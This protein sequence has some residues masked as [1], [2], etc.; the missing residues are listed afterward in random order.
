MSSDG[1]KINVTE[2]IIEKSVHVEAIKTMFYF[3]FNDKFEDKLEEHIQWEMVYVDRGEC[4]VFSD[5]DRY[6]LSQGEMYFHKPF[7]KH[8]IEVKKNTFPNIFIISFKSSS[9]ALHTLAKRKIS[10]PM[11]IKQHITAIIHEASLTYSSLHITGSTLRAES[12]LW[13][14]EQSILLRLELMLI[15][16][17]RQKEQGTTKKKLFVSKKTIDDEFCIRIIEYMEEKIYDKFSLDE[18]SARLSYSKSYISKHFMSVCGISIIEY[19]NMMKIEEAKM[20]IRGTNKSF[21]EISEMLMLTN[22][23]YFSTLFKKYVGMTPT[24]YK[25]S[26]R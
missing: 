9:P 25:K 14:G 23:H 13:A 4:T 1:T 8:K 26:C 21:F 22:S 11:N 17:I 5:D 12:R 2:R 6:A 18:I 19:F 3:E 24:Q 10:V 16:L 7:E 15:D 20:L